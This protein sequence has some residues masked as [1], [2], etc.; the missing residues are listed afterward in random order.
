MPHQDRRGG[1]I[2]QTWALGIEGRDDPVD[3]PRETN[4]PRRLLGTNQHWMNL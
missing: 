3:T 2:A 1:H 4:N